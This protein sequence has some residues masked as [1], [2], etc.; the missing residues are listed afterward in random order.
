MQYHCTTRVGRIDNSLARILGNLY[1]LPVFAKRINMIGWG[2]NGALD[3]PWFLA[4][5]SSSSTA[6]TDWHR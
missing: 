3:V 5:L 4:S 6:T 1:L 2:E